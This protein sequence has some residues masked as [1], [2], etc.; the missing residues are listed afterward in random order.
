MESVVRQAR[1]YDHGVNQVPVV[2]AVSAES[3]EVRRRVLLERTG[4][5][6]D[7]QSRRF[8]AHQS[9]RR[10]PKTA[11]RVE[12]ARLVTNSHYQAM[13]LDL[14]DLLGFGRIDFRFA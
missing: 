7:G 3:V 6:L 2:I 8:I 13:S 11:L 9:W 12:G 5:E 10:S 4:R 14:P 1:S